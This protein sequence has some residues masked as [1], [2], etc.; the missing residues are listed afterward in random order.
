MC[1]IGYLRKITHQ[2]HLQYT[3]TANKSKTIKNPTDWYSNKKLK[4]YL[5][6]YEN[7]DLT[8]TRMCND[9]SI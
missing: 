7:L 8:R 3:Y 4:L 1:V 9:I 6:K 5:N 2:T